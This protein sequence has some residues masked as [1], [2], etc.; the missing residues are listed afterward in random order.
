MPDSDTPDSRFAALVQGI[1]DYAILRLDPDGNVLTWNQGAERITGYTAA[2]IVGKHFSV[3]HTRGDFKRG[4]PAYALRVAAAEGRYE[5]EGWRVRKDGSNF[6]ANVV[7]TALRDSQG[8]LLGF[9]K[10][11]RDLSERKRRDDERGALIEME[12]RARE[13]AQAAF[14]RLRAIQAVT[15]AALSHLSLDQLLDALLDRIKSALDADTVAVLLLDEADQ[16]LVAKA[17]SGLEEE[18]ERG[19][20]IPLGTGFAGRVAS[21]R[22]PIVLADVEHS[23]VLNPVLREKGVRSLVGVPLLVDGRVLGVLHVGSLAPRSFTSADVEVLQ[24]VADRVALAIDHARLYADAT[25]ARAEADVAA[26]TVRARDEFISVAAHE[27]KTPMTSAKAA[28]QLLQR[29]FERGG[30]L[31]ATQKRALEMVVTQIDKLAQLVSQLLETV[32]TQEGQLALQRLRTDLALLVRTAA[33]Q[34]QATTTA[35]TVVVTAPESLSAWIDPLR[36]EQVMAN[37]LSNAVKFSPKGGRID[38]EV[39]RPTGANVWISVRDHGLG[40][41]QEHRLHL[42]ERFYQAHGDRSGM[43]LGLY[44]ARRIVESHGGTIYAEFPDDGGTRIMMSLPVGLHDVSEEPSSET[45]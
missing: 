37:L 12:R 5:E 28:A 13:E 2:E 3:F 45:A 9:A 18:V 29:T 32:R 43:G 1:T 20:R 15:E 4:K 38:V 31:D 26:A 14:E 19:V 36:L 16:V 30:S 25:A 41:P 8:K 27:L 21:E 40:V 23:E 6:W 33:A 42:F 34:T 22:R 24:I 17:A 44:I 39:T 7:M 35:H 10:I 11:T